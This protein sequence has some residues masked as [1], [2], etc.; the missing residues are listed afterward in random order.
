MRSQH[1]AISKL[2]QIR[3][4]GY[5]LFAMGKRNSTER[6][7]YFSFNHSAVSWG[8]NRT[9][10][11]TLNDGI[12]PLA[13]ILYICCGETP[14][15]WARSCARS[16]SCFSLTTSTRLMGVLLLGQP[17]FGTARR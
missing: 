7:G 4:S 17:E 6:T 10:L 14:S 16:A 1:E 2:G 9:A 5:A 3:A 8:S 12:S 11:A 15:N 13:A